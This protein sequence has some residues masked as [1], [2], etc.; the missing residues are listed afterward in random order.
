[1]TQQQYSR[2]GAA[3]FDLAYPQSESELSADDRTFAAT[4][5]ERA[6]N[7]DCAWLDAFTDTWENDDDRTGVI[8]GLDLAVVGQSLFGAAYVQGGL[9]CGPVHPNLTHFW[10]PWSPGLEHHDHGS[11]E[12]L[13]H[14]AV[15]WFETLLRRPVVPWLWQYKRF[16]RAPGFYA[17]RYE[18]ADGGDLIA[19]WYDPDCAPAA[20]TARAREGGYF[21]ESWLGP[22]L[23]TATLTH[24]DA[25]QFVRGDRS[26]ARI[27]DGCYELPRGHAV[28]RSGAADLLGCDLRWDTRRAHELG[29]RRRCL[30]RERES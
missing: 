4:V 20:E 14:Q 25:F 30:L 13:A 3:R 28:G 12:V 27:P 8:A 10:D 23:T 1:V 18:F 21:V 24:P 9:H 19:E 17:G 7:W 22:R 29:L 2:P 15:D 16:G 5:R 26:A 11:P 6:A